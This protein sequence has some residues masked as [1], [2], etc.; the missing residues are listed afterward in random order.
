MRFTAKVDAFVPSAVASIAAKY[1][2]ELAMQA[3]NTYWCE[4]LPDLKPTAGYPADARRF[5]REI[6]QLQAAEAISDR[7]LWRNR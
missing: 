4:R 1:L 3:F 6:A 2:R 5:K 7:S